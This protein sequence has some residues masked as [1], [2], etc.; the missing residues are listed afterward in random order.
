MNEEQI[1]EQIANIDSILASG[2]TSASSDGE[3]VSWDFEELRRRRS[4]LL[5]LKY[6]QRYRQRRVRTINISRAF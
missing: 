2:T 5:A 3:S 1:N 4:E 6:R